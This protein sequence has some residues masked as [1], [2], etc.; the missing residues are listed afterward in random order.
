MK[1]QTPLGR[2]LIRDGRPNLNLRPLDPQSVFD[3][4]PP[5]VTCRATSD[6]VHARMGRFSCVAVSWCCHRLGGEFWAAYD[7]AYAAAGR[8][9]VI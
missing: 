7:A 9:P 2:D 4:S 5:T 8:E 1:A 3:G 6:P